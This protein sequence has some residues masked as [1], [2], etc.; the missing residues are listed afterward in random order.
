[1]SYWSCS[2]SF[3]LLEEKFWIKSCALTYQSFY[4]ILT[5]LECIGESWSL[6]LYHF[7]H[8]LQALKSFFAYF[9][10]NYSFYG[11]TGRAIYYYHKIIYLGA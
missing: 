9:Q 4:G 3:Y 7:M 10:K 1:M 11:R 2:S 5:V 8:F 6:Y